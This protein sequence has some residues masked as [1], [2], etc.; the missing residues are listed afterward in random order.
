MTNE[1]IIKLKFYESVLKYKEKRLNK[2][3]LNKKIKK[4][5][6]FFQK[7]NIKNCVIGISGGIDS[8]VIIGLLNEVSKN[9]PDLNIY[10]K[11]YLFKDIYENF[12]YKYIKSLTNKFKNNKQIHFETNNIEN[13]SDISGINKDDKNLLGQGSYAFRYHKMFIEAQ[14]IGNCIVIGTTNL[15]EFSYSG[16]FGKNS[17]MM[18]DIQVIIDWHKFEV[19]AAAKELG[20][21]EII[22]NRTPTGDLVD[23]TT[24]ED[25][26]GCNYD[27]LSYISYFMCNEFKNRKLDDI[28]DYI[29]NNFEK[30]HTLNKKNSHKYNGQ[31]FNPI[32]IVNNKKFFKYYN[33]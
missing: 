5:T 31:T 18:V 32:M 16:W 24:D 27:E 11:C 13:Y 4:L 6:D 33:K 14:K 25:N 30:L 20:I 29:V 23:N 8:S 2:F 12:E 9:I 3:N 1:N 28:K 10:A 19:I 17:D 26:F 22:I 21:P 15:D 7:N